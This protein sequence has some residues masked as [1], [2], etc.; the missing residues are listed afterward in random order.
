VVSMLERLEIP[1]LVVENDPQRVAELETRGIAVLYGDAANS[2]ILTHGCLECARAL[3]VTLPDEAASEIVV[4]AA[5]RMSPTLPVIARAATATGLRRLSELGADEVIHPE[6][7]GGLEVMRHT[8]LGLG[9]P[10]FQVQEYTDQVRRE[11]YDL[12][13]PSI[14]E[15]RLLSQMVQ[16]TRGMEIVWRE[17]EAGN[18]LAGLTVAQASIRAGTGA[19]IVAIIRGGQVIPNP[20]PAI[21]FAPGDVVGFIGGKEQIAAVDRLLHER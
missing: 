17:L 3:V 12:D 6:L 21:G 13:V 15:H 9:F 18:P 16:A 8:L 19:S 5:R 4:S 14:R 20:D 1:S 7:E 10:P 2:E 11:L